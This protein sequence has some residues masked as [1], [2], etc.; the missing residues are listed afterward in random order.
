MPPILWIKSKAKE[1]LKHDIINGT[2][3][4]EMEARDVYE[5]HEEYKEYEFRKFQNNFRSLKKVIK[6]HHNR[7]QEDHAALNLYLLLHP[8]RDV[9]AGG[10]PFW[11]TSE[12]RVSLK[13]DIDSGIHDRMSTTELWQSRDEYQAFSLKK[14]R[15]HLTQ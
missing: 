6:K 11:D 14:F 12:A 2:V 7:A 13:R 5:M 4:D 8:R 9:T 3:N 1:I 15:D 10:F